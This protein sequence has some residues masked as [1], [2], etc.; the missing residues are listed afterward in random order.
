MPTILSVL[1]RQHWPVTFHNLLTAVRA[2]GF[3]YVLEGNQPVTLFAPSDEAFDRWH[4]GVIYDLLK[5][6][7]LLQ[8]LIASHIVPLKL[9]QV[10]LK[11]EA[12]KSTLEP[13]GAPLTPAQRREPVVELATV[14]HSRLLVSFSRGF[15][16]QGVPVIGVQQEADNGMIHTVEHILWPPHLSEAAFHLLPP[17]IPQP[18]HIDPHNLQGF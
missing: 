9:T 18:L 12:S 6:L 11:Q 1:Q 5:N 16:V 8:T 14:A 4:Q 17:C 10:M 7:T 15:R 2:V 13:P 3:E